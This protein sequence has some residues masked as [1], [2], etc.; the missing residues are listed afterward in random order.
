MSKEPF[1]KKPD[2]MLVGVAIGDWR[3]TPES[4]FDDVYKYGDGKIFDYLSMKTIVPSRDSEAITPE[5]LL[6]VGKYLSE[7]GIY[8][9][10][11]SD[12]R[13]ETKGADPM[14]DKDVVKKLQE[15]AGEYFLG[16]ELLEFGGYYASKSKGYKAVSR[17]KEEK[18]NKK[19]YS[20][21]K[22]SIHNLTN[23]VQGIET[24]D[25]GAATYSRKMKEVIAPMREAGTEL[26]SALEAVTLFPYTYDAGV[27]FCT[28]EVAPRNM[29]QIMSFARGSQRAYKKN[30]LG[31]WLAHDWYGGY[32]HDDPLKAK[33]LKVDYYMTYLAGLDHVCLESG[34]GAITSHGYNLPEY[35]PVTQYNIHTTIDFANFTKKDKRPDGGPITKVAFVQGNYDGFGW[36]NSSSLWGQYDNESFGHRAPEFSYRILDEVYRSS[37]W[38]NYMNS[39]DNDYSHCPAYGQYDVIPATIPLDVLKQYEWVIFCGWNTMTKEIYETFKAYVEGGGN[40]L[41]TAAHMR[42]SVDRDKKGNFVDVNWEELIGCKLTDEIMHTNNGYKFKRDGIIEGIVY[43][44][45]SGPMSD[46]CWSNGYTDYVVVEPTTANVIGNI[47]DS[48]ADHPDH[49]WPCV[50]E[51]KCGKGNVIFMT[52]SEYP[53]APEVYRLYQIM[54]KTVLAAHHGMS[55]LKVISSDKIR[56]AM[57]EDEKKYKMYVIN[58]DYNVENKVIV[59]FK[60]ERVEKTVGSCELEI[61]EF[62]K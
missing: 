50:L 47:S 54:V 44:G 57:F 3:F 32:K 23:P 41:I 5:F 36:G 16:N 4:F 24:V 27:D 55:D 6:E 53:G 35:H 2:H 14:Y 43:P 33:R 59:K 7:R 39:G 12:Y 45:T 1:N 25:E 18:K 51:N 40:L 28:V 62:K 15:I 10:V 26:V 34:Y 49:M 13:R 29:E 17:P 30:F 48:F 46:P 61:I 52:N 56:F 58:T 19:D 9:T 22:G 37:D 31:G 21:G 20:S 11:R 38:C 8:F 42:D 60:G